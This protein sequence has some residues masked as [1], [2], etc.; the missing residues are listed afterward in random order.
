MCLLILALILLP[1]VSFLLLVLRGSSVW[2]PTD[3]ALEPPWNP[4]SVPRRR[5]TSRLYKTP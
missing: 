4:R 5:W 1:L 2:D 3:R